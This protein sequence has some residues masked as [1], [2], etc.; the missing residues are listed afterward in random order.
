MSQFCLQLNYCPNFL[1]KDIAP[2]DTRRRPDQRALENG[3]MKLAGAEKER[4][5]N[6]QRAVRKYNEINKIEHKPVYFEE[7]KEKVEGEPFWR[8]NQ[9]YYENDRPKKEWKRLP[10]LY[11]FDAVNEFEKIIKS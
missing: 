6:K 7:Q 2:T 1:E 5:E 10:D 3:D 11:S 8:Y 9:T 4:L